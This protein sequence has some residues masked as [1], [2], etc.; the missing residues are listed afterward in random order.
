MNKPCANC[1]QVSQ[2]Q[3]MIR[4]IMNAFPVLLKLPHP[5]PK[6]QDIKIETEWRCNYCGV[7]QNNC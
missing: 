6:I 5:P 4:P 3:V 2:G 7:W 1:G